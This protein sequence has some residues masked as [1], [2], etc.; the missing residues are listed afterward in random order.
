[1][2]ILNNIQ[3][4]ADNYYKKAYLLN[5]KGITNEYLEVKKKADSLNIEVKFYIDDSS[6]ETSYKIGK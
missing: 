4:A 6:T 1:M 2:N 3:K 5:S